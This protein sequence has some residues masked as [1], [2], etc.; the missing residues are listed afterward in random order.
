MRRPNHRRRIQTARMQNQT[1]RQAVFSI[2]RFGLFKKAS[3]LY[4]LCSAD[5]SI[6]VYSPRN[7]LYSF[8][9][10]FSKSIVERFVEEDLTP[11]T[12]DP[13]P[14]IIA[15]Q[16]ANINRNVNTLERELA[17]DNLSFSGLKNLCEALE[18]A[19]EEVERVVSQLLEADES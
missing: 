11:G 12:N 14:I 1:S 15:L 16:N 4:S 10:P 5:V 7:K 2:R 17:K 3:E 8:W 6:V 13:N 9:H 19:D 18:A